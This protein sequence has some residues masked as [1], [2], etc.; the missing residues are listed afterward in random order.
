LNVS[1]LTFESLASGHCF[2][3]TSYYDTLRITLRTTSARVCITIFTLF[4]FCDSVQGR[5]SGS[6]SIVNV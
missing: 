1:L 3:C 2:G 5:L 4:S 6:F